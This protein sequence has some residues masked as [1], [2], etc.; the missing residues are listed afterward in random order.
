MSQAGPNEEGVPKGKEIVHVPDGADLLAE[1]PADSRVGIV[2]RFISDKISDV[3]PDQKAEMAKIDA[4]KKGIMKDVNAMVQTDTNIY[5]L[6]VREL[7]K[8][9]A[10]SDVWEMLRRYIDSGIATEAKTRYSVPP[11]IDY[12]SFVLIQE[13]FEKAADGEHMRL[14]LRVLLESDEKQLALLAKWLS[15]HE[16]DPDKFLNLHHGI[17]AVRQQSVPQKNQI[18]PAR[19]PNDDNFRRLVNF[20]NEDLAPTY[21]TLLVFLEYLTYAKRFNYEEAQNYIAVNLNKQGPYR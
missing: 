18:T 14:F 16:N 2:V 7:K 15:Y 10:S 12:R 8:T 3:S 4:L 11:H 19:R 1:K 6:F 17:S 21:E 13:M 20:S 5:L 9:N